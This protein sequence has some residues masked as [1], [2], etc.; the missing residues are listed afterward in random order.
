MRKSLYD[1]SHHEYEG[2]FNTGEK[3]Q[4]IIPFYN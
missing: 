1:L 2:Q 3:Q 4:S